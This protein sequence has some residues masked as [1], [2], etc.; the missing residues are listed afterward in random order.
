MK[1]FNFKKARL[2]YLMFWG[3]RGFTAIE[4][5]VVVAILS[6]II[7][8]VLAQFSK[9]REREVLKSATNNILSSVQ[10]ARSQTLAS[11]DS[12]SYGVHF[13]SSQVIIF[14]GVSFSSGDP[15][16]EVMPIIGPA[17]ISNVT[18]GGVSGSS[19]EIYFSRLSGTPSKTG[20]VTVANN[21]VSKIITIS[22]TGAA[23]SN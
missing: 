15:D 22:A 4:L 12:S 21:T 9:S 19:G 14:K 17:T 20:T 1:L 10:K 11:L 5:V 16:N 2:P 23:S 8:V 13:E 18:L 7:G 3:R 6:L